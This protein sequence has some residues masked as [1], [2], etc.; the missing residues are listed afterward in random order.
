MSKQ[1]AELVNK[2]AQYHFLHEIIVLLTPTT[3]KRTPVTPKELKAV[4]DYLYKFA[5]VEEYQAFIAGRLY[6]RRL[7]EVKGDA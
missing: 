3:H 5:T 6:E 2:G 7:M 4:D 1:K